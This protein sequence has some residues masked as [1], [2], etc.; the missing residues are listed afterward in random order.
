MTGN[1]RMLRFP[2]FVFLLGWTTLASAQTSPSDSSKSLFVRMLPANRDSTPIALEESMAAPLVFQGDTITTFRATLRGVPPIRRSEIALD[3]LDALH[4]DQ[5]PL[6]VRIEPLEQGSV[7]L[8]GDVYAFLVLNQDVDPRS[9]H[10]SLQAAEEARERLSLA[11]LKRARLLSASG[12]TRSIIEAIVGTVVL[13]V[14]IFILSRI[15]RFALKWMQSKSE[16]HRQRLK[17]GDV[18]FI[19]QFSI[20][21]TWIARIVTQIGALALIGVWIIFTLN[22]FPE[23]LRWGMT[24]RT[25]VLD[26]L[27]GF[28]RSILRAIPG[29]LAIALI[30]LVTRFV[31]RILSDLFA[32]VE[33]G[34][35]RLP[36]VHPETAGATR[37][38]V[39]VLVWIFAIVFA[40]PFVPGSDSAAFQGV[41]VFLGL[42]VTLGSSGI[43]GHMMAGLVV[44][45]SRALQR[46][47][48]VRV[49]EIEGIVTEVGTLSVKVT[50]AIK[51]EFTIPNTV[52]VGNVVK[53]YSRLT[54]GAGVPMTLPVTIGYDVPWRVVQ[55]MLVAA[56]KRTAGVLESPGPI[57]LQS[58]LSEFYVEY[59][60]VV[61]VEKPE[62]RI[63]TLTALHQNIQ[64]IF[65]ERGVQIMVPAFESQPASP[66]VIPKSKWTQAPGDA[67]S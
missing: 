43:V 22:R 20:A 61:R 27:R 16:V 48:L 34:A 65:Y 6:P 63:A 33:R 3:R 4:R 1:G 49:G 64:D 46:G 12:R 55:E 35:I 32:G 19:A 59:Q 39:T 53:N 57:V 50:N 36:G 7:V 37:R 52:I 47:D 51:E 31:N 9:G 67:A 17:L 23:T 18:D 14:L 24:A 54:R 5:L 42:I 21:L 44:V 29:M 25:S 30:I 26:I 66:L 10:T 38:L 56:A 41:S 13:V 15:S 58:N 40:Y 11:L 45:Y 28:E 8:V 2:L 60:L 62:L